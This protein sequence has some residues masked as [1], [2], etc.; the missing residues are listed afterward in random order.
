M[1]G[2]QMC[3][4]AAR[5][6]IRKRAQYV[7][8]GGFAVFDPPDKKRSVEILTASRAMDTFLFLQKSAG[9]HR[10][11]KRR[12]GEENIPRRLKLH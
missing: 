9:L 10:L 2:V 6:K 1:P 3:N 5:D 12:F 4:E 8:R 7:A 11:R